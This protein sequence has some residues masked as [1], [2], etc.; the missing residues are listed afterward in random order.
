A[1]TAD[2]TISGSLGGLIRL[3]QSDDSASAMLE[4]DVEI[5]GDMRVAEGFSR[6]LANASIDWEELLSKVVG[7]MAAYQ[8]GSSVRKGNEWVAETVEAMKLNTAEYLSEESRMVPAKAEV[9]G[10]MEAVDELQMA[11]DR[12][13][14]RVTLLQ[15][16]CAG[17]STP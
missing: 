6:L 7:D 15:A 5:S 2:A 16:R 11:A 17:D 12:L 9:A 10:F 4:S 8:V 1:G 14:A 3:S 13:D